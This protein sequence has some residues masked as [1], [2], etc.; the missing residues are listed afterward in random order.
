MDKKRVSVVT[1]GTSGIGRGI[2]EKI[3][4][5][6][7]EGD[8]VFV[9]YAHN[10]ERA[11]AFAD[12]LP[13]PLKTRVELVKADMSSYEDMMRFVQVIKDRA[14]SV[15]WLV[16]NAGISTYAKYED[17]TF[18]EWTKIVN[19]NL[20][21]PVFMVKELR[22][23]MNEGGKLLFMGSY[24]GRQAYSSSL[25]YGVTKA[26]VHFLTKSLVKEFEPKGITVNAIAP[27][28]IQT[29]WHE[30]RSQESYDRINKK[31]ALHRFGDVKDVADLAYC[32]LTN[33]YMN[34]SIVDI[35]GGY[36]YF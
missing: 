28:F 12:S 26:A 6:S 5:H 14:G 3:L 29:T 27:G 10:E 34:G 1:G 24:A 25:V 17:Y 9:N 20:S 7:S 13:A 36:D 31:I 16:C 33:G 4:K 32:I 22:P 23:V 2:A 15:D 30:N 18:E 19:T 11:K 35:H 8:L 21:I